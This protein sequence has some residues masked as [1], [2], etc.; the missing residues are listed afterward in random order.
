MSIS[1]AGWPLARPS[2][3]SMAVASLLLAPTARAATIT[4][5]SVLDGGAGCTLRQAVTSLNTGS[6]LGGC[7]ADGAAFGVSDTILFD[8]SVTGTITLTGGQLAITRP[9]TIR[10]P[11]AAYLSVSGDHASRVIYVSQAAVVTIRGLTIENGFDSFEGGGIYAGPGVSLT[12]SNSILSGNWAGS[13]G[14]GIFG[15]RA[16]I[17]LTDSHLFENAAGVFGGGIY[18]SR[19]A[20]TLIESSV[21]GNAAGAFGGGIYG[22]RSVLTLTNSALSDNWAELIG[23]GI[24]DESSVLTLAN[25]TLTGNSAGLSG[26][27]LFGYGGVMT[28]T[29]SSLAGNS[30]GVNGGGIYSS[31]AGMTLIDTTLSGNSAG[32]NGGAIHPFQSSITL[33]NSTLS[34]NSAASRGG[35]IFG[36]DSRMEL[37][38]S[39]VSGNSGG[40]DAGGIVATEST[41]TLANSIIADNPGGDCRQFS[42]SVTANHTL[43][44]DRGEDACDLVDSTNN[45][46]IGSDP[47]LGP[48]VDNGCVTQ[49]GIPG[50]PEFGCVLTHALGDGSPALAAASATVCAAN[51]VNAGDQRGFARP[52]PAGGV[53][54]IGAVERDWPEPVPALA[55]WGVMGGAGLLGLFGAWRQ[56]RRESPRGDKGAAR[57]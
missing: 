21:S 28:L 33:T 27:G 16:A 38:H 31:K 43:I 8:S 6:E 49:S 55:P 42:S 39:T 5:D 22:S 19:S 1:V 26:G 50:T 11:G 30:A 29:N 32:V 57:E 51:P 41:M 35:G 48:L 14:G 25:S 3:L 47:I 4:V 2:L 36:D 23:G 45:N 40:T 15:S 54:D 10:G 7:V 34:T 56:R 9:M 12:L 24:H 17:M 18:G 52:Q 13:N 53:C 20:L 37:A 46:I 44:K